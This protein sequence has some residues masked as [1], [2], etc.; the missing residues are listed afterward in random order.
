[1]TPEPAPEPVHEPTP[2][3]K[4]PSELMGKADVHREAM[5][6]F[7]HY[8]T[9]SAS[10]IG[11]IPVSF[12][13]ACTLFHTLGCATQWRFL[14][15]LFGAALIGVLFM[16]Y[17]RL[18]LHAHTALKVAACLE[19]GELVGG[20]VVLGLAS[21]R[22]A[23]DTSFPTLKSQ[24]GGTLYRWTRLLACVAA[25]LLLAIAGLS[26]WKLSLSFGW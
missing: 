3:P 24:N 1:M 13:G 22:E 10:A 2:A 26:I 23:L 18:D 6:T 4:V 7:R 14:V 16:L 19:R 8:D 11:A 5:M 9:L 15:P 21:T 17:S 20:H 12:A 25:T